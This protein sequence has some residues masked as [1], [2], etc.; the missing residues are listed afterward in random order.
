MIRT[1]VFASL[2]LAASLSVPMASTAFAAEPIKTVAKGTA[3]VG[4]GIVKGTA[5]VGRGIVRGTGTV[6]KKTG[7]GV[8]CVFTLG[9][10]CG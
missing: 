1:T 10:R 3:T 8:A 2:V 9:N 4:K 7:K 5:T 6:L